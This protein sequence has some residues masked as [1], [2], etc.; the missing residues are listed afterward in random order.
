MASTCLLARIESLLSQIVCQSEVLLAME[1]AFKALG[2]RKE[3]AA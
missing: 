1:D 2:R 3:E